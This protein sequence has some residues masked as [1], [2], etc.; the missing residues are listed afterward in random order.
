MQNLKVLEE[1]NNVIFS[2][3][4][5]GDYAIVHIK[6]TMEPK[7]FD[8]NTKMLYTPPDGY[9]KYDNDNYRRRYAV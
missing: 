1:S 5:R 2:K 3:I 6:Y 9:I 7:I 8:H 4:A